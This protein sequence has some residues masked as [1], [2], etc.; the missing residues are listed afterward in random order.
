MSS[1]QDQPEATALAEL[2]VAEF[3]YDMVCLVA[4]TAVGPLAPIAPDT[5]GVLLRVQAGFANA[6]GAAPAFSL[7]ARALRSLA[8]SLDAS[9]SRHGVMPVHRVEVPE[10]KPGAS[11]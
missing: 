2:L 1:K 3:G 6:D 9:A 8:D 10:P 5:S 11:S 4:L 7:V